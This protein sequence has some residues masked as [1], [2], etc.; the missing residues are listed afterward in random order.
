MSQKVQQYPIWVPAM[1]EDTE[2]ESPI[3]ILKNVVA[4]LTVRKKLLGLQRHA[5]TVS[6][7]LH[8][9]HPSDWQYQ[10]LRGKYT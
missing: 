10:N 6:N 7:S 8:S 5:L 4:R 1:R 9:L 3:A 2:D